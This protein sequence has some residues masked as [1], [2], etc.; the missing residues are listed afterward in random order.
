[1]PDIMC[2]GCGFVYK[3]HTNVYGK[4]CRNCGLFIEPNTPH[5]LTSQNVKKIN[6]N[7]DLFRTIM[8]QK[9]KTGDR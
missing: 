8:R 3:G 1:M 6:T 9:F 4:V 5:K 7:R 2:P